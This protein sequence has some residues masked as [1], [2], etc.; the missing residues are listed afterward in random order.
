MCLNPPHKNMND[1]DKDALPP[2]AELFLHIVLFVLPRDSFDCDHKALL[3]LSRIRKR[4]VEDMHASSGPFTLDLH[5]SAKHIVMVSPYPCAQLAHIDMQHFRALKST[6]ARFR[7]ID[8]LCINLGLLPDRCNFVHTPQILDLVFHCLTIGRA[9][10]LHIAHAIFEA[11]QFT[12][13]MKHLFQC[14][15]NQIL[16]VDLRHCKLTMNSRFLRELASMRNLTSLTLDGN[17]FDLACCAFPSFSDKLECL[18][19][20]NCSRIRPSILKKVNKTLRT[21]VWSDNVLEDRD[22]QDFL[23]WITDS[24]LQN[25][26]IDNCGLCLTDSFDFQSAFQRMPELRSLSMAGNY[27]F[28][29]DV[30]WW[31]YDIWRSRRLQPTFFSVHISNMH[32]CY[33]D[34]GIPVIMSTARFSY[35]EISSW[36]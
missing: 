13:C 3:R 19:L 9:K 22:K 5:L 8:R 18:S 30:F 36:D 4:L 7:S 1:A 2:L 10:H 23:Q 27:F 26:D 15:K 28:Q 20:S 12:N 34:A 11:D 17:T 24:S 32:I 29:D 31:I 6:A 14:T 21:L 35:I 25:L 16:S 33:P